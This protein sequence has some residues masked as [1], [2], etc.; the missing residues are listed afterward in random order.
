MKVAALALAAT[1]L[2]ASPAQGEDWASVRPGT[3]VGARLTIGGKNGGEPVAA[4]TI[5]PTHS[6]ISRDGLTSTRIGEGLA[7]N[8]TA[9]HKPTLTLGGIRADTALGMKSSAGLDSERRLGVSTG[10]WV[11]I[12]VGAAVLGG[13]AAFYFTVTDCAD[14]E[15][16]CP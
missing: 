2:I 16:E 11:A 6:R 10:A 7:L 4:L 3:F 12:G 14:H 13:A 5:A 15:D 8:F 9:R 1:A